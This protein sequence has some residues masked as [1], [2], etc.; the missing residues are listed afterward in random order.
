[1]LVRVV[2]C[3]FGLWVLYCVGM[4][5]DL[6]FFLVLFFEFWSLIKKFKYF[7][8]IFCFE[9]LFWVVRESFGL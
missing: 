4:G 8:F 2:G 5:G 7:I 6:V 9:I 3:G 1:V